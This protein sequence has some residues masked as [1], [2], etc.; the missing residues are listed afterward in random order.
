V[1]TKVLDCANMYPDDQMMCKM[2]TTS[3]SKGLAEYHTTRDSYIL[4]YTLFH[5]LI[6]KNFLSTPD[7]VETLNGAQR[8]M[9]KDDVGT[10]Y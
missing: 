7:T 1:L 3:R 4:Q 10:G 2:S 6:T 8:L 5:K 9:P